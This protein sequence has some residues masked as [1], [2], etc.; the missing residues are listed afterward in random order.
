MQNLLKTV[1]A[2]NLVKA[3]DQS[4]VDKDTISRLVLKSQPP[5]PDDIPA[6]V[7]FTLAWGGL[8]SGSFIQTLCE[9]FKAAFPCN[10]V[11]SGVF[12]HKAASL[13]LKYPPNKLPV[14]FVNALLLTQAEASEKVEDGMARFITHGEVDAIGLAKNREK[15]HEY[16]QVLQK[17]LLIAIT[18]GTK[19]REEV[20]RIMVQ[21][22]CRIIR[23]Y[24]GRKTTIEEFPNITNIVTA[25]TAQLSSNVTPTASSASSSKEEVPLHNV[26][27]YGDNDVSLPIMTDIHTLEN[28]GFK[29]GHIVHKPKDNNVL[30]QWAIRSISDNKV[31]LVSTSINGETPEDPSSTT[32]DLDN[33]VSE[34]KVTDA[35]AAS[36]LQ[37]TTTEQK[38]VVNMFYQCLAFTS[39][40]K[41]SLEYQLDASKFVRIVKP[42]HVI[43]TN[44]RWEA[45]EMVIVPLT[46]SLTVSP[47]STSLPLIS[48]NKPDAPQFL[49][50]A[51]R[52]LGDSIFFWLVSHAVQD[53]KDSNCYIKPLMVNSPATCLPGDS[54]NKTAVKVTIPCIVNKKI[55][56]PNDS[57]HLFLPKARHV[58]TKKHVMAA[59]GGPTTSAKKQRA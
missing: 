33:F 39:L 37:C 8:P 49:V 6:L 16:D 10:R 4:R 28:K 59:I 45:G 19:T 38:E 34:Y 56:Q 29:I 50:S 41:L 3:S 21:F 15:V 53:Q 26:V 18:Q 24:L 25:L 58:E 23:H 11:V 42:V 44:V 17:A 43:R 31:F 40:Y 46:T 30:N 22:K 1:H 54:T 9:E 5:R 20:T 52:R 35:V 14:Y 32:I 7:D 27:L 2:Y 12:F 57:L 55:L 47:S 48:I 51:N 13:S 36:E